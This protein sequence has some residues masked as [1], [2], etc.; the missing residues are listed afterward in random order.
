MANGTFRQLQFVDDVKGLGGS[1]VTLPKGSLVQIVNWS[2]HRN[3]KLWG[4]D[5]DVFNPY[6]EF[7]PEELAHV[8]CSMAAR[9]PQS[10]RFSPFAHNPRSCLGKNFAQMEMRLILVYLLR[11]FDFG[12]AASYDA[13][14]YGGSSATSLEPKA[15]RG[16][17]RGGTMGPLDLERGGAVAS[18]GRRYLVAMKLQV[19]PRGQR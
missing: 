1:R 5:A 11:R 7:A 6:R 3:P 9:S 18:K 13:L 16:V 19:T 2:R 8:G 10:T 12:L 15:F 17:N 14:Q 4:P